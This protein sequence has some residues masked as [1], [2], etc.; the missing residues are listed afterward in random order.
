MRYRDI[1][2]PIIESETT[3]PIKPLSP[4]EADKRWDAY[5]TRQPRPKKRPRWQTPPAPAPKP[6]P[7]T[8]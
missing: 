1:I 7:P 8:S 5:Q 6:T 4:A 2:R 3:E